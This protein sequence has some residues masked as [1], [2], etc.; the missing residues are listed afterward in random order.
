VAA[1]PLT[2]LTCWQLCRR[3][4]WRDPRIPCQRRTLHKIMAR[5]D[6]GAHGETTLS[7][8]PPDFP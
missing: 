2:A 6:I 3:S 5:Q 8:F 4:F 1:L 7:K